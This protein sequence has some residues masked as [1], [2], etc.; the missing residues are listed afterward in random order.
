MEEEK[1]KGREKESSTFLAVK[2]LF[3]SSRVSKCI[4]SNPQRQIPHCPSA[5]PPHGAGPPPPLPCRPP[6][7]PPPPPPPGAD[8]TPRSI[9]MPQPLCR[10]SPPR[11]P[12]NWVNGWPLTCA[13]RREKPAGLIRGRCLTSGRTRS[14]PY[15]ADPRRRLPLSINLHLSV[16]GGLN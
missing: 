13:Q 9:Q 14:G 1:K 15:R 8:G 5:P 3:I 2:P 16:T 12:M 4:S 7:P 6:H 10:S 11:D